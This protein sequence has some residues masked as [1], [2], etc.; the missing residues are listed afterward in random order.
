[1]NLNKYL[2]TTSYVVLAFGSL[3]ALRYW[4]TRLRAQK[5]E[6][7]TI[8]ELLLESAKKGN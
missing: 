3:F 6:T 4:Y 5:K 2:R 8:L 1:M 7:Q